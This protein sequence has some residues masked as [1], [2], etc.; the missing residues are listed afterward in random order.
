MTN[1]KKIHDISIKNLM[2]TVPSDDAQ[3][4][5]LAESMNEI[6]GGAAI[7]VLKAYEK[8]NS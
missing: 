6:A 5:E 3:A 7:E 8:E 1:F 2:A 4:K